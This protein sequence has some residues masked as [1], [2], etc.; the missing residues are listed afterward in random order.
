MDPWKWA[1]YLRE[2]RSGLQSWLDVAIGGDE[3]QWRGFL[4]QQ[5]LKDS[6]EEWSLSSHAVL[7]LPT[8]MEIASFLEE[9]SDVAN[10]CYYTARWLCHSSRPLCAKQWEKM[11]ADR[12][13]ALYAAQNYFSSL[14]HSEVDWKS[15]PRG[16]SIEIP[17]EVGQAGR[18]KLFSRYRHTSAGKF[19]TLLE[20]GAPVKQCLCGQPTGRAGLRPREEAGLR[21]VLHV[22]QGTR[23]V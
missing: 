10:L 15:M 14:S 11:Y 7:G 5:R 4:L 1:C 13:P 20:V 22:G 16:D 8:M 18:F 12:W 17:S 19:E 9:P 6:S 3:T 23:N 21:N 2:T